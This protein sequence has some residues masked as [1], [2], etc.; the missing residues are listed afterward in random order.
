MGLNQYNICLRTHRAQLWYLR[1]WKAEDEPLGFVTTLK[2]SEIWTYG[3]SL[4]SIA[5]CHSVFSNTS[6]RIQIVCQISHIIASLFVWI[7][8]NLFYSLAGFTN[9]NRGVQKVYKYIFCNGGAS[10]PDARIFLL[11]WYNRTDI[12]EYV[13]IWLKWNVSVIMRLIYSLAFRKWINYLG[14]RKCNC[15][16][17]TTNCLQALYWWGWYGVDFG[18][19]SLLRHCHLINEFLGKLCVCLTDAD[20]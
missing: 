11:L 14:N 12:A 5:F 17:A 18:P 1:N 20:L 19:C 4:A 3:L 7:Y 9:Q 15:Y 8:S 10:K 13:V 16:Q 6:I 2:R